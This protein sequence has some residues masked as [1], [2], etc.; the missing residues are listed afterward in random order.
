MTLQHT[1]H[2]RAFRLVYNSPK[3]SNIVCRIRVCVSFQSAVTA[4]KHFAVA[5]RPPLFR[6]NVMATA[7]SLRGISRWDKDN[8]NS[9]QDSFV[10][11]KHPELI[12]R[13][14]VCPSP[15][16]LVARLGIQRFANIA[17]VFKRQCR[18]YCLSF[19]H[20]LSADAVVN[21]FLKPR[22]FPREPLEESFRPSRA[23][24]LKRCSAKRITVASSLQLATIPSFVRGSGCNVSSAQIDTNHLGCFTCWWGVKFNR[25]LDVIVSTPALDQRST[26]G[27]LPSKQCQ[28]IVSNLTRQPN[29][30]GHQRDAYMLIGLPVSEDSGIQRDAGWT[31]L[32]NLLNCFQ[33]THHSPNG[34]ADMISFQSSCQLNPV[35]GQV[36]QLGCVA[37]VLVL[38]YLQYLITSIRKSLQSAVNFLTQLYRDLKFTGYRYC[39]SHA[40]IILHPHCSWEA[41]YPA[42][43]SLTGVGL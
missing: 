8:G 4:L 9:S 17:Q 30:F 13:P 2:N 21:V 25:N 28:L 43:P 11:D 12:K 23:F 31:K 42:P 35:V 3:S 38:G 18:T 7:T 15:F 32:V 33:I 26:G 1:T 6:V 39:L 27:D 34:L 10:G 36:M 37:A 24:G 20:Q 41:L 16:G 14:I 5:V 29:P 22:F 40:L 19:I